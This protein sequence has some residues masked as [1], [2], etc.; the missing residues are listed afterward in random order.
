MGLFPEQVIEMWPETK[1]WITAEMETEQRVS[2]I[3]EEKKD[4]GQNGTKMACT[5][6]WLYLNRM[7]MSLAG[8]LSVTQI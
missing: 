5:M 4:R 1:K 8:G 2:V 6:G 3:K 7:V